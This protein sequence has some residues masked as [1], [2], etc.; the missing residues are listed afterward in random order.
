MSNTSI[1]VAVIGL[2]SM[3]MGAAKSAVSAGIETFGF[4]LNEDT[5]LDFSQYGGKT[6]NSLIESVKSVDVV[7]LM[8][9]NAN[10]CSQV[11]FGEGGIADHVKKNTVIILGSTTSASYAQE[12]ESQLKDK[13]LRMIDAPVSGGSKKANTGDLT[14]MASGP[15][16]AFETCKIL[17]DA[18]S[19]KLYRVSESVGG[20][21]SIKIINQLLAGVHIA[22]AAEA[23]ALG[24]KSNLN[25]EMLYEI[26]SNSAGSSWMFQNR[27]P[28]ILEG[29]Y[30]PKSMVDI[31]VKDLGIVL[32]VGMEM[33]F[34]LPL[35]ASA[36]QQFLSASSA[37]YG[38]E[39]DSAVI[40]AYPSIDLPQKREE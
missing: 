36:H 23:M 6:T 39:N 10:Q 15:N 13:G 28:S 24:L 20:G 5:M 22:A 18:I 11:L 35:T 33:K 37:G 3:G 31:F 9:V 27:V 30:T 16:D 4:D 12:L 26:I 1:K 8:L 38:Q 19:A 17:F 2:G 40:K 34:P 7:L 25:L 21:A 14:I 29:D 32:D